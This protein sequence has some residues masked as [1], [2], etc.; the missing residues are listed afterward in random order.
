MNDKSIYCKRM[1]NFLT[2][3]DRHPVFRQI[4]LTQKHMYTYA[5]NFMLFY[6][7]NKMFHTHSMSQFCWKIMASVWKPTK[8]TAAN[9]CGG[10]SW[11][12]EVAFLAWK[13]AW[14]V[15]SYLLQRSRL[16]SG[17]PLLLFVE[18]VVVPGRCRP[19]GPCKWWPSPSGPASRVSRC[20]CDGES[21][22][23]S[24]KYWP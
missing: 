20:P 23:P 19:P 7:Q 17:S 21:R 5:L 13:S 16:C 1:S 6:S 3:I 8:T 10:L 4:G 18:Y 22:I 2:N 11:S 12:S 15:P 14:L 24:R 9:I